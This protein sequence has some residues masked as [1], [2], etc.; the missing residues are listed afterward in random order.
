MQDG[1]TILA[2]R[3]TRLIRFDPDGAVPTYAACAAEEVAQGDQLCVVD[4][5]FIDMARARLDIRATAAEEIR[6]YHDRVRQRF[7]ML[8]GSTGAERLRTLV[9]KM[10]APAVQ[11]GTARA[12]THLA[13]E[14]EKPLDLVLPRAPQEWPTFQRFMAALGVPLPLAESYW[15][16]AVVLTRKTRIKAA[17]RLHEAYLAILVDAFTAEHVSPARRADI[18]ALR[19]SAEGYVSVVANRVI[20]A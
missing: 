16:W 15:A 6:D 4:D 7:G 14:V 10:G 2:R 9:R 19:A 11:E 5:A 3:K 17:Q 20:E 12:W 18:R 1:R 8:E 13:A